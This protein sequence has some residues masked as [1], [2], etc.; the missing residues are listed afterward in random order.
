MS[1]RASAAA[2]SLAKAGVAREHVVMLA[3]VTLLWGLNWPALKVALVAFEP[4]TFRAVVLVV[5][6]LTLFLIGRALG[7]RCRLPRRLWRPILVPA[8]M[9][10]G[11]H[12]CSAFGVSELGGGRAAIIAFTMPLWAALIS[13]WWLDERLD[14][15]R[16]GALSLGLL[17]L[18]LLMAGDI[19]RM[20]AA[21]AGVLLMLAAALSWAIGTVAT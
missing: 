1:D 3:V 5:S 19:T 10:T 20:Q 18:G 16:I 14:P 13:V 17:G 4:W 12:V 9:V 2:G 7:H 21:P 6:S 11:W 8:A 15:R